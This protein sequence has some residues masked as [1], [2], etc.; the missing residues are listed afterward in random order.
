[1][2]KKYERLNGTLNKGILSFLRD[3]N[4]EDVALDINFTV[5]KGKQTETDVL[6]LCR[7]EQYPSLIKA[8]DLNNVGYER[9][10]DTKYDAFIIT[11]IDYP[12]EFTIY[13]QTFINE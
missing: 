3:F 13:M 2:K 4:L 5:V 8:L 11:L 10:Y 12:V 7:L 9:T 6:L 1:M